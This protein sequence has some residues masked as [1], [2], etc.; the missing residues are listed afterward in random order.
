MT[1]QCPR[2]GP[3]RTGFTLMELMA[4]VIVLAILAGVALPRFLDYRADARRASQLAV[5]GAV[6]EGIA[7]L[8]IEYAT[9]NAAGLPPDANGDNFPDHLG[10]VAR[11]EPTLFDAILQTPIPHDDNGWK[12]YMAVSWPFATNYIYHYDTNGDNLGTSGEVL[13]TYNYSDDHCF[14]DTVIAPL[15]GPATFGMRCTRKTWTHTR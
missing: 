6:Q 12:Q 10:D 13:F 7:L 2:A 14:L 9:G 5:M 8:H 4:V 3:L 11:P 15:R 1:R